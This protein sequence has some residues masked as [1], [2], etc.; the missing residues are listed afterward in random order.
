MGAQKKGGEN[1][2]RAWCMNLQLHNN[3]KV[4]TEMRYGEASKLRR[5]E[6]NI[7]AAQPD[8]I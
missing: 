7:A 1:K 8:R 3:S 4:K 6:L 2:I 5:G